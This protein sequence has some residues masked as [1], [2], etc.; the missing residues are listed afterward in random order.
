[1]NQMPVIIT[2][3]HK[4]VGFYKTLDDEDETPKYLEKGTK[5]KQIGHS[6]YYRQPYADL[7]YYKVE[8]E[9]YGIGYVPIEM[10]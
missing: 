5:L 9:I 1:M 2:T 4:N 3:K 6:W 8:H 10:D 7:G